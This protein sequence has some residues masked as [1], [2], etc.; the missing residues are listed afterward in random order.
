MARMK[1]FF[2]YLILFVAFYLLTDILIYF[3]TK[4]NYKD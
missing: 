4:D 1:T 3:S 2:I